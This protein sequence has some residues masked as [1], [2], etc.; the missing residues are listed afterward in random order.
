MHVADSPHTYMSHGASLYFLNE[1][2]VHVQYIKNSSL[3]PYDR[4]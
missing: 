2:N 1:P 4:K 3:M